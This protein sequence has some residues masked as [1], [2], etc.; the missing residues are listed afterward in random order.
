VLP[1]VSSCV[2]NRPTFLVMAASQFRRLVG[3]FRH[4]RPNRGPQKGSPHTRESP[5]DVALLL[6]NRSKR[7]IFFVNVPLILLTPEAFS[8][9][10]CTRYRLAVGLRPDP[11]GELG[12]AVSSPRRPS[13]I[14]CYINVSCHHRRQHENKLKRVQQMH[15]PN[16]IVTMHSLA[17]E[18]RVSNELCQRV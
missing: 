8:S 18:R 5:S 3:G 4:V 1:L 2:V 14:F 12:S 6:V 9:P 10:K 17:S 15:D 11:L 13:W 16:N 7:N